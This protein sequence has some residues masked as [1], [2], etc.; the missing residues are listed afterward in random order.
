MS[1]VVTG[2]WGCGAYKGNP[3]LKRFLQLMAAAVAGREVAYF[4]FGDDDLRDYIY[5][6]YSLVTQMNITTGKNT[7]LLLFLQTLKYL[8]INL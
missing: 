2:N 7:R 1:A 4:S 8:G 3:H 6:L 5:N